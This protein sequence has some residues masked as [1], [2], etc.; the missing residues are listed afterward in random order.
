MRRI[1]P[2]RIDPLR[3]LLLVRKYE[4]PEKFGRIILPDQT[5]LDTT[6]SFWEVVKSNSEAEEK[7]GM[8]IPEG[9]ILKVR[10][11]APGDPGGRFSG[12]YDPENRG[13]YFLGPDSIYSVIPKEWEDD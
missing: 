7:I 3:D 13:L 9:S 10:L 2:S 11:S 6:G 8:E 12:Y 4:K 5:R 1:D